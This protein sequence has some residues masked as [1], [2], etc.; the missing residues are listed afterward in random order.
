MKVATTTGFLQRSL[1][2]I[3]SDHEPNCGPNDVL[4]DVYASSVNP[5]DWKLNQNFSSLVPRLAGYAP[6]IIGDDLAGVVLQCGSRVRDFAVGDEIYGMD[7]NWRTAACAE[8]AVI[9]QQKI[10]HKPTTLSFSEAAAVPLAGLTALQA[11]RAGNIKAGSNVLVIG[12]SG[13]V[14]CFAIQIAKAYGAK[15]TGVCSHRNLALVSDLG[16]DDVID[17]TKSDY[18]QVTAHY[19]LVFDATSYET[20]QACSTLL[21]EG[22]S[23]ISTGGHSKAYFGW[24]AAKLRPN[25]RTATVVFVKPNTADLDTLRTLIDTD[26]VKV[27]MD[28][29]FNL[30]DIGQ[31]YARS[32]TGRARGKI[33]IIIR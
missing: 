5:K 26:K 21:R 13:G 8:R 23:F 14:G 6:K 16:A 19:D 9:S 1:T 10:A 15:V 30:Q 29:Q 12:A 2:V 18:Q 20:P 32:K 4:I 17:Y 11:L 33:G 22:G 28:S 25:K 7:M 24:A 3:N 31:A 27:V